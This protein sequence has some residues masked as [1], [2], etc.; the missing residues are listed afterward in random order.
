[1]SNLRMG[2]VGSVECTI[3]HDCIEWGTARL[4]RCKQV[5]VQLR[6][7]QKLN[8]FTQLWEVPVCTQVHIN[9]TE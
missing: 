6:G 1:M 5:H 9:C 3:V 2:I 4:Y 8:N 7:V